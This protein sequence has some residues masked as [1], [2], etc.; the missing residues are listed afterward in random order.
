M[1]EGALT[2]FLAEQAAGTN[3]SLAA[4]LLDTLAKLT[5]AKIE[6]DKRYGHLVPRSQVMQL[7]RLITDAVCI[8]FGDLT[9]FNDRSDRL[10][11]EIQKSLEKLKEEL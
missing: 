6:Q 5:G 2:R 11:I 3:P 7:A 8:V 9:D 4:K 1:S 10:N